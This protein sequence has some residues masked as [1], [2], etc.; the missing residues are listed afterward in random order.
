MFQK[1]CE[2]HARGHVTEGQLLIS[3]SVRGSFI[4]FFISKRAIFLDISRHV[5]ATSQNFQKIGLWAQITVRFDTPHALVTWVLIK[6]GLWA[7]FS[8]LLSSPT[9]LFLFFFYFLFFLIFFIKLRI[10]YYFLNN[11]LDFLSPIF[12]KR[13]WI[14]Q[15]YFSIYDI[16]TYLL[17][18]CIIL[19]ANYWISC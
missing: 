7:V 18:W 11:H 14:L 1:V 3:Y 8:S 2:W 17:M 19:P 6:I 9:I 16:Y 13:K 5:G 10:N 12:F 4:Q 15:R